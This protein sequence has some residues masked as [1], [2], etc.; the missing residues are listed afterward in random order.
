M[1]HEPIT[2][3]KAFSS[4]NSS[5]R[6]TDRKKTIQRLEKRPRSW[7]GKRKKKKSCSR[8]TGQEETPDLGVASGEWVVDPS[9][10]DEVALG[11]VGLE[12]IGQGPEAVGPEAQLVELGARDAGVADDPGRGAEGHR[13]AGEGHEEDPDAH[14]PREASLLHRRGVGAHL[15]TA[16]RGLLLAAAITNTN[17][18]QPFVS[19]RWP[20]QPNPNAWETFS[21]VAP[22]CY[23]GT[24][25]SHWERDGAN[26]V[27]GLGPLGAN[28]EALDVC[29]FLDLWIE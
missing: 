15:P 2:R 28:F 29:I 20:T 4:N 17:H 24:C 19:E 16:T 12:G 21:W 5:Y 10:A 27:A 9:A 22:L 26:G 14:A 13:D 23:R 11:L 3:K 7:A 6:T 8:L 1:S 18:T 25:G